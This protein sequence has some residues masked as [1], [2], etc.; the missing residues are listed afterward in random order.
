MIRECF[1]FLTVLI[2]SMGALCQTDTLIY[3]NQYSDIE[4]RIDDLISRMTLEEKVML[5][6][7]DTTSYDSKP[8]ERIGIP[9]LR[10][11]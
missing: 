2:S 5:L 7:G 6:A 4:D 11:S 8:D 1:F 9:V 3:K 10:Y